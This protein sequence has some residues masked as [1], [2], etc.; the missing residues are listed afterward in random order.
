MELNCDYINI[1]KE[2][3]KDYEKDKSI[4]ISNNI[5]IQKD[6][7]EK[8]KI[9]D[10]NLDFVELND[11]KDE[12]LKNTFIFRR[13]GIIKEGRCLFKQGYKI[14]FNINKQKLYLLKAGTKPNIFYYKIVNGILF[15]KDDDG[16]KDENGNKKNVN[17]ITDIE[18]LRRLYQKGDIII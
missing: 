16:G 13:L 11:V 15:I 6:T 17:D 5:D 2:Y 1:S 12:K 18:L 9:D 4:L 7:I 3:L 10:T 14:C 8:P